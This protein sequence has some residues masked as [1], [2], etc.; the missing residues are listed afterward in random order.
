MNH[1]RANANAM[2]RARL[3]ILLVLVL[4]IEGNSTRP[5]PTSGS[6]VVVIMFPRGHTIAPLP[7]AA[8]VRKQS[9]LNLYALRLPVY[10]NK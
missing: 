3:Q 4:G 9:T 1:N 10:N 5:L 6:L 8:N 7:S 2:W